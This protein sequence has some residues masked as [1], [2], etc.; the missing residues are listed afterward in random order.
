[1]GDQKIKKHLNESSSRSHDMSTVTVLK[2]I[3]DHLEQE[4]LNDIISAGN[5]SLLADETTDMADRAVPSVYIHYVDPVN[6]QVKDVYL[7]LVEIQD[8]KGAETLCQKICEVLCVKGLDIKQ[9]IF[10]GLDR[11][12]AMSG[13]RSGLQR[14]LRHEPPHSKYVNCH[15]HRLALVLVHLIPQFKQLGKLMQHISF[16]ESI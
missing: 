11:T 2:L 5:F 13:E 1:M 10:H 9:L 7:G 14:Q 4:L 6:N 8:S 15:S 12:S 3:N 16:V